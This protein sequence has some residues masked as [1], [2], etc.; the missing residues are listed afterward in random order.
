MAQALRQ[1]KEHINVVAHVAAGLDQLG[2]R[3]GGER[4]QHLRHVDLRRQGG[5]LGH[6][7]GVDTVDRCGQL[8]LLETATGR[9]IRR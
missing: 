4:H 5:P 7:L 8:P 9:L 3:V 6:V 2:G 1:V